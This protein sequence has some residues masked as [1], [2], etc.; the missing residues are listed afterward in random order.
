M[1]D[2]VQVRKQQ[3][4][5]LAHKKRPEVDTGWQL[6]LCPEPKTPSAFAMSAFAPQLSPLSLAWPLATP[7]PSFVAD[8]DSW[9]QTL[10]D[11][12]LQ[13]DKVQRQY[14]IFGQHKWV[15]AVKGEVTC[16]D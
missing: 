2:C 11:E 16:T 4:G 3:V 7:L 15:A 10:V 9:D 6:G 8:T 12:W 13:T 5:I 1:Q 14:Q